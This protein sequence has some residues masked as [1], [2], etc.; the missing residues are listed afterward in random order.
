VGVGIVV[1]VAEGVSVGVGTEV[2]AGLVTVGTG[3]GVDDPERNNSTTCSS[4]IKSTMTAMKATITVTVMIIRLR[5]FHMGFPSISGSSLLWIGDQYG[6][7]EEGGIA[8]GRVD[9]FGVETDGHPPDL[10][11]YD[12]RRDQSNGTM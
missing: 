5:L 12:S 1:G 2:A 3:E 11:C 10:A 4:F 9:A 6:V 8:A 7:V